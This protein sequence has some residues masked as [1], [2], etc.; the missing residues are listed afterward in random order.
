MCLLEHL[1]EIVAH[2]SHSLGFEVL[3]SVHVTTLRRIW[4]SMDDRISISFIFLIG[5]C[6][7][8]LRLRNQLKVIMS[9]WNLHRDWV[10]H[11]F[12]FIEF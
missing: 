5:P 11:V 2:T 6:K 9:L 8:P 3:H 1:N 4:H 10:L 12:W 7:L